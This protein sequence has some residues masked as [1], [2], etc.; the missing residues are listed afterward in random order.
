MSNLAALLQQAPRGDVGRGLEQL[1]YTV[2]VDGIPS[3]PDGMVAA[4]SYHITITN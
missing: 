2:L 3:N 4:N 1:R